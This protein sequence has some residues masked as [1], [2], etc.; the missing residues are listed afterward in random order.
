MRIGL[1]HAFKVF[2]ENNCYGRLLDSGLTPTYLSYAQVGAR[3]RATAACLQALAQAEERSTASTIRR[4]PFVAIAGPNALEWIVA[5]V[6]CS[7]LLLPTVGLHPQWDAD[8][9]GTVL[10][11]TSASIVV[12]TAL[13]TVAGLAAA[14]AGAAE[15]Q[16][17]L[18]L[19]DIVVLDA[20]LFAPSAADSTAARIAAATASAASAGLRLWVA[21]PF[22]MTAGEAASHTPCD[23]ETVPVDALERLAVAAAAAVGAP[24]PL[25]APL[26][27]SGLAASSTSLS[28]FPVPDPAWLAA[29]AAAEEAAQAAA[30]GPL[31]TPLVP[32]SAVAAAAAQS[33]AAGGRLGAAGWLVAAAAG[34]PEARFDVAATWGVMFATGSSGVLKGVPTSRAAWASG[35]GCGGGGR[36]LDFVEGNDVLSHSALSHGLDRGMVRRRKRGAS[37]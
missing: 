28:L 12:A 11:M 31:Y 24:L 21:S 4:R 37:A 2:A 34:D 5:D 23:R 3:V 10:R 29:A 18:S 17:R 19:H 8:K 25:A 30:G 1:E 14:A 33:A 27:D 20:L 26:A 36:V 7:G 32:P 6:A 16:S 9:L 22:L 35:A 15:Q 13:E